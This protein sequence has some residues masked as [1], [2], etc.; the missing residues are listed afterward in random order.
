MTALRIRHWLHVLDAWS[1]TLPGTRTKLSLKVAAEEAGVSV[2]V[3]RAWTREI[4]DR[5]AELG[6]ARRHRR[7]DVR[8]AVESRL[9]RGHTA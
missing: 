9:R 2:A 7:V 1:V 5:W 3:V 8:F 4:L 6:F